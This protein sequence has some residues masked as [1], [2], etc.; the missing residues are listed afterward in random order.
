MKPIIPAQ[1][2]FALLVP[3][4]RTWALDWCGALLAWELDG[5]EE[6]IPYTQH[7]RDDPL[8]GEHN[9]ILHP[10]GHVVGSDFSSYSTLAEA[11]APEACA[12]RKAAYEHA[13]EKAA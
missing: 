10:D 9:Y 7:G 1:P 13:I 11:N 3:D 6:A 12:A 2:G 4:V 8:S 5:S